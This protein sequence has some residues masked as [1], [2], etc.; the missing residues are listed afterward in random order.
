MHLL[1]LSDGVLGLACIG[2]TAAGTSK[3]EALTSEHAATDILNVFT[4]VLSRLGCCEDD[5]KHLPLVTTRKIMN[6]GVLEI[7]TTECRQEGAGKTM[8]K[9]I[10]DADGV[11]L[12][13]GEWLCCVE[14]S[15]VVLDNACCQGLTI[16]PLDV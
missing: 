13:G 7:K 4:L 14:H 15:L 12:L 6:G 11:L 16:S 3:E 10:A 1:A 9:T 8:N 2:A 5:Q